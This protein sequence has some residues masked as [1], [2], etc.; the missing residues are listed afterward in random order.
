MGGNLFLHNGQV[1]ARPLF[2]QTF[3]QTYQPYLQRSRL[4]EIN[5]DAAAG[6][7]A[8]S[9]AEGPEG[10]PET[11]GLGGVLKKKHRTLKGTGSADN[12]WRSF[13]LP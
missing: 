11:K 2:L 1:P 4:S 12:C 8:D 13:M 6:P 9:M 5:P 7:L 10:G 3:L